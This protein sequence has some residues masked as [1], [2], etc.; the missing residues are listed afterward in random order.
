MLKITTTI[1]DA[2]ASTIYNTDWTEE[3]L[4]AINI[5]TEHLGE[6]NTITIPYGLYDELTNYTDVDVSKLISEINFID[7]TTIKLTEVQHSKLTN[8]SFNGF[9]AHIVKVLLDSHVKRDSEVPIDQHEFTL[10]AEV[11]NQILQ[12]K[13]SPEADE[14]MSGIRELIKNTLDS[15]EPPQEEVS[16]FHAKL[17]QVAPDMKKLFEHV[18]D[19]LSSFHI[20]DNYFITLLLINTINNLKNNTDAKRTLSIKNHLKSAK[21]RLAFIEEVRQ[22]LTRVSSTPMP[23][24]LLESKVLNLYSKQILLKKDFAAFDT[25]RTLFY[26]LNSETYIKEY[27]FADYVFSNE[28]IKASDMCVTDTGVYSQILEVD[29]MKVI[30]LLGLC[31]ILPTILAEVPLCFPTRFEVDTTKSITKFKDR[32]MPL[33]E[34][35]ELIASVLTDR[36]IEVIMANGDLDEKIKIPQIFIEEPKK[37]TATANAKAKTKGNH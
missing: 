2:T 35:D 5:I 16:E 3:Q 29:K 9:D 25:L 14:L 33:K 24:Y 37:A 28:E 26:Q 27:T 21:R 11:I 4:Q 6:N 12:F 10:T 22:A 7:D 15:T 1:T 13:F 36:I 32:N 19:E 18:T 30:N 20:G 23:N 34:A 17:G 31:T 8:S